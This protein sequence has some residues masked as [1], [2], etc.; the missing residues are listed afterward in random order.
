MFFL[1]VVSL[2]CSIWTVDRMSGVRSTLSP[3]NNVKGLCHGIDQLSFAFVTPLRSKHRAYLPDFSELLV[4]LSLF[5]FSH[6]HSALSEG[7]DQ[8]TRAYLCKRMLLLLLFPPPL[9][10]KRDRRRMSVSVSVGLLHLGVSHTFGM[11]L[12]LQTDG[13][14]LACLCSLTLLCSFSFSFSLSF[15]LSFVLFLFDAFVVGSSCGAPTRSSAISSR[16]KKKAARAQPRVRTIRF[17]NLSFSFFFFHFF[18]FH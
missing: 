11:H 17:A 1:A 2:L 7:R 13:Q 9:V 4:L 3:S 16:T 8:V 15:S 10:L 12:T 14:H 18:I 6:V 5:V